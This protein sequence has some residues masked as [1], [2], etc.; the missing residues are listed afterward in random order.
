MRLIIIVAISYCL[1]CGCATGQYVS[2]DAE[3]LK[4]MAIVNAI[5]DYY[6]SSFSKKDSIFI[7][8]YYDSVYFEANIV[9]DGNVYR[10][11]HGNLYDGV[12][13][14]TIIPVNEWKYLYG[15]DSNGNICRHT[16]PNKLL[17]INNKLFYWDLHQSKPSPAIISILAKYN[18]LQDDENGI[19][20]MPDNPINEGIKGAVYYYGRKNPRKF[21]RRTISVALGFQHPPRIKQ[22]YRME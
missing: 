13:A 3:M 22:K 15:Q 9:K 16:Y 17:I 14:V 5:E 8:K 21:K 18:I 1:L 7:V 20:D 11:L 2:P 4:T 19:V 6:S 12:V 10:Y